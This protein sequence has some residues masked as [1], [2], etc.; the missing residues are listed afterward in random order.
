VA[1][2]YNFDANGAP[3]VGNNGLAYQ[4]NDVKKQQVVNVVQVNDTWPGGTAPGQ[5]NFDAT[6][7]P[8]VGGN[9]LAYQAGD[10]KKAASSTTTRVGENDV[11][12]YSINNVTVGENRYSIANV[13][14]V[15]ATVY[16]G[17]N[18]VTEQ[19]STGFTPNTETVAS[20][21]TKYENRVD[22]GSNFTI[23][24]FANQARR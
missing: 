1:G 4:A 17:E 13:Q 16:N 8:A 19:Y 15:T 3:A 24:E 9:G 20:N 6:G 7:A 14:E 23:S 22:F 11:T 10:V 21:W 18:I 5:Y 2:K 12:T